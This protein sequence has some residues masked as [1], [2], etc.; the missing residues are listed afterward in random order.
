M[1]TN[2]LTR[3]P[4]KCLGMLSLS[5]SRLVQRSTAMSMKAAAL[6]LLLAFSKVD[7][8]AEL[9][10]NTKQG[11]EIEE[12]SQ[13]AEFL[14]LVEDCKSKV[15]K[16][17]KEKD[18]L[19]KRKMKIL[20][21]SKEGR[22]IVRQKG[23]F[24]EEDLRI[25]EL[26]AVGIILEKMECLLTDESVN[27]GTNLRCSFAQAVIGKAVQ[28]LVEEYQ[29]PKHAPTTYMGYAS[30]KILLAISENPDFYKDFVYNRMA[31]LDTKFFTRDQ[32]L[33]IK[34]W[35]EREGVGHDMGSIGANLTCMFN[36]LCCGHREQAEIQYQ[37]IKSSDRY[38]SEIG[39]LCSLGFDLL[40]PHEKDSVISFFLIHKMDAWR[41]SATQKLVPLIRAYAEL[42]ACEVYSDSDLAEMFNTPFVFDKNKVATI[43][44]S[45]LF[46]GCNRSVEPEQLLEAF[47][48]MDE[49][50]F[51]FNFNSQ[52]GYSPLFDAVYIYYLWF[53][54]DSEKSDAK[55]IAEILLDNGVK[56][57]TKAPKGKLID[58]YQ[59]NCRLDKKIGQDILNESK[60]PDITPVFFLSRLCKGDKDLRKTL[61]QS[62][63]D[64]S[65][66]Y[67]GRDLVPTPGQNFALLPPATAPAVG[68]GALHASPAPYEGSSTELHY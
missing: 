42:Q 34:D 54:Q 24:L 2:I 46:W 9:V 3:Y 13:K 66:P 55:G 53:T 56:V 11:P 47:K 37:L 18:S 36:C 32:F 12:S 29:R 60:T 44:G 10:L 40:A 57:K 61:V 39:S 33:H 31:H 14:K 63:F 45:M 8:A 17:R 52:H 26:D 64:S 65:G 20:K 35:S 15:I 19:R 5:F 4:E 27:F 30:R 67:G 59:K 50:E 51:K 43:A 62:L 22:K 49:K 68:E 23:F 6:L 25:A 38:K 48:F 1:K 41:V 7:G 58:Y 16:K 21:K 28:R